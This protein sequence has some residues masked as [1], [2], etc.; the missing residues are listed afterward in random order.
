MSAPEQV[1]AR[2]RAL[3]ERE[4]L[5]GAGD[6]L[7]L[8]VSG[9]ADSTC[10]LDVMRQLRPGSSPRMAV[11]HVDH[12]YRAN[13]A[14]DGAFVRDLATRAGLPCEVARV[15]GPEY[16]RRHRLGLEQAGR[17]L[18][19]QHLAR[20]AVRHGARMIVT[21]H[22]RDD[23]VETM[24]MHLLRGAGGEGLR[25]IGVRESLE[26]ARLGPPALDD[27]PPSATV[28]RPLLGLGRAET[29]A[30]CRARGLAWRV[31]PSNDDPSFLRNRVRH[32]LLP[33]LRTYNPSIDG[34]LART[35]MLLRD[36]EAWLEAATARRGRRLLRVTSDGLQIE[37]DGWRRQPRAAQRRLARR[38]ADALGA[39]GEGLGFEAVE[40][41][42]RFAETDTGTRLELPNRLLLTRA[43]HQ[44]R[45]ARR[46]ESSA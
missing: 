33:V 31:D 30:Y 16:A 41:F 7:I 43:G 9:G 46:G 14:E 4:R 25:G 12:A 18:R 36:D 32:H 21:G 10:L 42:L 38:A 29:A 28:I 26:L 2:V 35:A 40:R 5:Y 6:F 1:V 24:L 8:A 27:L 44:L 13:S 3:A 20:A 39:G 15:D 23:S 45:L 34:T 37:L 17:A 19:Y 11:V 22:S